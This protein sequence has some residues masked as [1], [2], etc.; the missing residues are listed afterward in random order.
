MS[1]DR[2][3]TAAHLRASSQ[4]AQFLT[5]SSP[6]PL[7]SS[8]LQLSPSSPADMLCSVART[9]FSNARS[10]PVAVRCGAIAKRDSDSAEANGSAHLILTAG[11][12]GDRGAH[13]ERA[14]VQGSSDVHPHAEPGAAS[15]TR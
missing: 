2:G 13:Y 12:G 14:G 1:M 11:A 3:R 10:A 9:V 4:P 5:A 6:E 15:E 8:P 7:I